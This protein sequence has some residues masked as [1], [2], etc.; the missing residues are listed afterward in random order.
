MYI[1]KNLLLGVPSKSW[2]AGVNMVTIVI[3]VYDVITTYCFEDVKY[4]E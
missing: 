2:E 4:G 3:E 1:F